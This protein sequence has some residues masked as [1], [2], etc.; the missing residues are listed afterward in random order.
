MLAYFIQKRS[1]DHKSVE[2]EG[3][4]KGKRFRGKIKREEGR[5]E[6]TTNVG[7][8]SRVCVLSSTGLY[9]ALSRGVEVF[10]LRRFSRD[11]D[12]KGIQREQP[13][14]IVPLAV[15]KTRQCSG[16]V[17]DRVLPPESSG[18]RARTHACADV[19]LCARPGSHGRVLGRRHGRSYVY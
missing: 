1:E 18:A 6:S 12:R 2:T 11:G 9:D 3:K 5:K 10:P 13:R 15:N 4:Q 17:C 16:T 19:T 8:H 14:Y 7:V